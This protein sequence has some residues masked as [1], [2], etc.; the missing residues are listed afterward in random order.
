M[1]IFYFFYSVT[2]GSSDFYQ[3]AIPKL[4]TDNLALKGSWDSR[5]VSLSGKIVSLSEPFY[6]NDIKTFSCTNPRCRNSS[7]VIRHVG[8]DYL[9]QAE[10]LGSEKLK[11]EVFVSGAGSK[12]SPVIKCHNCREEISELYPF[13]ATI[14]FKLAKLKIEGA[15]HTVTVL[16]C[17]SKTCSLVN[18][19]A[20]VILIGFPKLTAEVSHQLKQIFSAKS[21][22]YY[23]EVYGVE[24]ETIACPLS[25][26]ETLESLVSCTSEWFRFPLLLLLCQLIGSANNVKLDICLPNI[27]ESILNR[28]TN[29]FNSLFGSHFIG[30]AHAVKPKKTKGMKDESLPYNINIASTAIKD[31]KRSILYT[32][33]AHD[34]AITVPIE[35]THREEAEILLNTSDLKHQDHLQLPRLNSVI[36]LSKTAVM[37]IHSHFLHLRKRFQGGI[38]LQ[39]TLDLLTKLTRISAAASSRSEAIEVDADFAIMLHDRIISAYNYNESAIISDFSNQQIMSPSMSFD[40]DGDTCD[41]DDNI[42]NLA[43]YYGL[44]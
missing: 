3:L 35:L 11:P 5:P 33:L 8:F 18:L 16:L 21:H 24:Q 36:Q 41:D 2:I 14:E 28:I 23:F 31:D 22:S 4:C 32:Q 17:G 42:K 26:K 10:E 40:F 44:F 1:R 38:P 43:E 34:Q 29:L 25:M 19:S 7:R 30:R 27:N 13:R 37:K 6:L 12:T 39:F 15:V 9:E 20:T